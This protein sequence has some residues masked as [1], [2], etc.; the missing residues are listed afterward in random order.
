MDK[1]N[2][3]QRVRKQLGSQTEGKL[4]DISNCP[5]NYTNIPSTV[6]HF[7]GFAWQNSHLNASLAVRTL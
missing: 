2:R 4:N 7:V 6:S 1:D 5:I 3:K